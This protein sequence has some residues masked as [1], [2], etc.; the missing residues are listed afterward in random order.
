MLFA[1]CN[2]SD[3]SVSLPQYFDRLSTRVAMLDASAGDNGAAETDAG[4]RTTEAALRGFASALEAVRAPD[5]AKDAHH[6]LTVASRNL[7]DDA[8]R[9]VA[10]PGSLGST[11]ASTRPVAS[12]RQASDLREWERACHSLQDLASARR[13]DIDLRCTTALHAR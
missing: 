2:R 13:I 9:D 5:A 11:P 10:R 4:F 1:A 3:A 8:A 7:A 12:S 6:D